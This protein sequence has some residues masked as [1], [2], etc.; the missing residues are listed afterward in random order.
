MAEGASIVVVDVD[1]EGGAAAAEELGGRFIHGDVA[2]ASRWKVAVEGAEA[3]FGGVDIAQL[4][5]GVTS[6]VG[7][8]EEMSDEQYQR[9]LRTNIDGIAYGICAVVPAMKRRGGGSVVV[10]SAIAAVVAFPPD[11][12][13]ALTKHAVIGLIRSLVPQLRDGGITIN[14]V[15]PADPVDTP[16]VGEVAK[17]ALL[18]AGVT[19]MEPRAI[20]DAAY[21][22]LTGRRTGE[23]WICYAGRAP[24]AHTFPD[25]VR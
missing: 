9:T 2:D 15:C 3:A 12:I 16:M 18:A 20:A 1:S 6:G 14:A 8:I 17:A 23:A 7:L 22:C 13:Y 4:N 24:F 10:T 11:P 5:P 25:A 19:L 21:A